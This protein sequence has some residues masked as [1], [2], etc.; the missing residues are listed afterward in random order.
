M[1]RY[2]HSALTVPYT[3]LTYLIVFVK[4]TKKKKKKNLGKGFA[5]IAHFYV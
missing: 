1:S 2:I 5:I 3:N 4:V